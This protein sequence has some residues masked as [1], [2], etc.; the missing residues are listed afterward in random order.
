MLI[1]ATIL[2]N[3]IMYI[4]CI[5]IFH[6]T[7]TNPPAPAPSPFLMKDFDIFFAIRKT[8][9]FPQSSSKSL[10]Y[11]SYKIIASEIFAFRSA[12]YLENLV[13]SPATF[14]NSI[15][16]YWS[17]GGGGGLYIKWNVS[18][19]LES[20]PLEKVMTGCSVIFPSTPL[21]SNFLT[22]VF[23]EQ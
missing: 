10:P 6:L 18:I 21:T 23:F 5:L 12:T 17:M 20:D 2:R 11:E 22:F 19:E 9:F 7:Y 14:R 4:I 13:F 15:F 1:Y 16:Y 8:L 3:F